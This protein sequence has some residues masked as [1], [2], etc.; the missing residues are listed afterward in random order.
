MNI[1]QS[2]FRLRSLKYYIY[3]V[4]YQLSKFN[5][6]SDFSNLINQKVIVSMEVDENEHIEIEGVI[7]S[8]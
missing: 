8:K 5:K 7:K 3:S 2:F 6:M 4:V 1:L